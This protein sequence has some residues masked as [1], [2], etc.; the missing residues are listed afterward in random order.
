[1]R[2]QPTTAALGGTTDD[3][4]DAEIER[5]RMEAEMEVERARMTAEAEKKQL[6]A[7]AEAARKAAE[8]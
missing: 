8:A 4:K 2:K 6:A 5:A 1:M 7:E 3:G